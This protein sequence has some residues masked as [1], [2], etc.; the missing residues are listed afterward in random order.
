[1]RLRNL[2]TGEVEFLRLVWHKLTSR[3][4]SGLIIE[5]ASAHDG[6]PI[7]IHNQT[8]FEVRFK[9]AGVPLVTNLAAGEQLAYAWDEP[10]RQ[11]ILIISVTAL[12]VRFRCDAT[13]CRITRPRLA[14]FFGRAAIELH[15]TAHGAAIMVVLRHAS[16][17][18]PPPRLSVSARS[19]SSRSAQLHAVSHLTMS[20]H[21]S[22]SPPISSDGAVLKKWRL[23]LQLSE[24]GA[25]LL[26]HDARELLHLSLRGLRIGLAH[27]AAAGGSPLV[28]LSLALASMQ[29]DCQL[30][31]DAAR[32]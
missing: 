31:R 4:T 29:L 30:P 21:I 2:E 26:D 22:Q 17:Q 25:T 6:V 11:R 7:V 32:E 1:L 19:P 13:P 12:A 20:P 8:R 16:A 14:P 3:A 5:E 15:T 18:L 9:Q 24:F 10:T 28:T 23:Q 27:D